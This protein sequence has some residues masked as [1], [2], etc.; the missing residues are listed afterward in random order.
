[1]EQLQVWAERAGAKFLSRDLGA[2][3][4][5]LAFDAIQQGRDENADAVLIDT[6]GRLQNK[7]ELMDELEKVIRVIKK[8]DTET[9]QTGLRTLDDNTGTL[10]PLPL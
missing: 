1:M 6:A 7:A 10:S 5:G 9:Q 4:A 2:D 8:H 3:A